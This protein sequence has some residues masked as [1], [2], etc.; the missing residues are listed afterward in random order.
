M[1][2]LS[3]II[4]GLQFQSFPEESVEIQLKSIKST[5][6]HLADNAKMEGLEPSITLEEVLEERN[7]LLDEAKAEIEF[8]RMQF[9]EYRQ[10]QLNALEEMRN[11]W[12]EEKEQLKQKAYEEAFSQGFDDGIKKAMDQM[13][14]SI[15]KSNEMMNLA[16]ENADKYIEEQEQVILDL[17][18]KCAE[19][20][21]DYE[22]ERN[23]EAFVSIIRR[24]LKEVREL[25]SVKVY[26]SAEYYELLFKYRDELSELFPP[27]VQ[28]LI[29]THEDLHEE[30]CYIESNHGRIIA[31]VDEQLQEL[32]SKLTEILLSKG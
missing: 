17:A 12:E 20:I 26:V 19:K 5:A 1:T 23:E 3:K 28:F 4:R 30:Q 15:E 2:S 16:K 13:S 6:Q 21:L 25:P 7:R 8:E 24:A 22:L 14:R 27:D 32:R 10:A 29:F 31:T 11:A 18:L 9:E